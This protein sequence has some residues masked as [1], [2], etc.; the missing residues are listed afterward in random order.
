MAKVSIRKRLIAK[1][2]YSLYLDYYPPIVNPSTKKLQRWEYLKLFIYGRPSNKI[3]RLHNKETT[4]LS[5]WILLNRQLD[6]QNKRYGFLTESNRDGSFINYFKK[7][8]AKR[9]KSDSDNMA[10]AFRYFEE[11]VSKG[12]KFCDLD[13]SVC[14]AF[15]SYLL[16]S[17]GISLRNKPITRNTAAN[18]FAKFRSALREAF[19]KGL[20]TEDL[21]VLVKPIKVNETHRERLEL[22]ELQKLIS[23]PMRPAVMKRAAIFSA[24]TGLRFS[25]VKALKWSELR[26]H[27]GKYYLQYSQQK[28]MVAEYMPISDD[29]IKLMGCKKDA[30]E[31]VFRNL[32]YSSMRTFLVTWLAKAG[33]NKCITF[34]SFRHTYAT[35]QLEFG[36][37]VY[38]VSKMLGHKHIKT[39]QVYAKVVDR[40]KNQ[41]INKIKVDFGRLNMAD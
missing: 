12:L 22:E 28:T 8:T 4:Q 15:R 18:Y 5:E 32:A 6:V 31:P 10:M 21:Y 2:R 33:I 20:I 14:D 13:E 25:D 39:T 16:D 24:L 9:Q 3:E 11:F 17:P 40:K 37:D 19:S 41:T 26:G 23:T 1:N 34:H 7:Y 29:A 30:H 38:T 35:L 27:P 36:T